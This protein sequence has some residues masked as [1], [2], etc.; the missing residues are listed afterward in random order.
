MRARN[1]DN[2]RRTRKR[3]K[4]YIAFLNNALEALENVLTPK[5][6]V[7][8]KTEDLNGTSSSSSSSCS[9]SSSSNSS[10][11]GPVGGPSEEVT[12]AE[13]ST[14]PSIILEHRLQTLK[15]FLALR[16]SPSVD[17]EQFIALCSPTIVHSMPLPAH[18]DLSSLAHIS[19]LYECKG[20]DAIVDDTR[21]R[22]SFCDTVPIFY[23]L[24][25]EIF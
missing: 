11:S 18:R 24:P 6:P 15:R 12:E 3:K 17:V 8:N 19:D 13:D 7:E 9:S 21:K 1:R 10:S 2:A 23:S 16:S 25:L 14:S 4:I 5:E 22:A 20:I